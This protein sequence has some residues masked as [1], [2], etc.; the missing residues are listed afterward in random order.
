MIATGTETD[1]ITFSSSGE[2][3]W[4]GIHFENVTESSQLKYC[5]VTKCRKISDQLPGSDETYAG[6]LT[7]FK[8]QA[9]IENSDLSDNE[10]GMLADSSEIIISQSRACNNINDGLLYCEVSSGKVSSSLLSN[11]SYA[12]I[13]TQNSSVIIENNVLEEHLE[14][15]ASYESVDTIIGNVLRNN[16]W[17]GITNSYCNPFIFRNVIYGSNSG[18]SCEGNPLIV[19]NT[20]TE[21]Y[22]FGIY[23]GWNAK[24]LLIN[25]IIYGN[26]NLIL[27]DTDDTVVVANCLLQADTVP[28]GLTDAGGNIYNEDPL[29]IDPGNYDFSLNSA[30]PCI[31]TGIAYFEWD[32]E[33]LLN[34]IPA[35]YTGNAPD[36]GAIETTILGV[37]DDF[38]NLQGRSRLTVYPNPSAGE[39]IKVHY[40]EAESGNLYLDI[41]NV[42]GSPV[43]HQKL[44]SNDCVVN[45]ANL[46][47][48]VYLLIVYEEG[49]ILDKAKIVVR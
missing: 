23:C 27:Y 6:G 45:I 35:Q 38:D 17:C 19:N 13:I 25:D 44:N 47:A 30:S 10:I 41:I 3:Y 26:G 21:N 2:G 36:I 24:P 18:I 15:I 49:K 12:G 5:S 14:G 8:S 7:F 39:M 29:F 1:S 33:V 31:N 20:I 37:K 42:T 9:L 48:G 16:L 32:G 28:A 4:G 43:H 46:P 40:Q 22:Y 34:L 11:N